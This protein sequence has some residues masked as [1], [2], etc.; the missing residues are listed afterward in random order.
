MI[1]KLY[2]T[3]N[4]PLCHSIAIWLKKQNIPFTRYDIDKNAKAKM[5]MIKKSKQETV[6]VLMADD[7]IMVG[8]NGDVLR[9]MFKVK[10][11]F[12]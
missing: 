5:E 6:P 10:T 4:C 9:D 11:N 2:E 12:Y 3:T 8:L 1:V 7:K